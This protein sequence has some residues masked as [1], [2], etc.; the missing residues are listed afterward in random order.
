MGKMAT[1]ES[2]YCLLTQPMSDNLL[3]LAP[4]SQSHQQCPPLILIDYSKV[5]FYEGRAVD[6]TLG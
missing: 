1:T 6:I 3:F 4:D 2:K 5:I